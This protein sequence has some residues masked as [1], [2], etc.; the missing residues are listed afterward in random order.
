MND[1]EP[2]DDPTADMD[3]WTADDL[4]RPRR[5]PTVDAE[6]SSPRRPDQDE[7]ERKGDATRELEVTRSILERRPWPG[8]GWARSLVVVN[9]FFTAAYVGWWSVAGHIG[10]PILFGLLAAAEVFTIGHL[11]GLWQ[12]L[13]NDG[14]EIPPK[15]RRRFDVDVFVPTYGESLSTLRRTV[16]AAVEMDGDHRTYV[17][18]DAVRDEVARLAD[19]CGAEYIPREASSGAKAGNLN[20]ALDRTDGQLVVVF[21]ADHV[22]RRDFLTRL[23]GYFEDPTVAIVQTPQFY[24]NAVDN[25]VAR[26]AWHQ[27]MIFYGPILRGKSD[28]DAAFLCGTN[29]I[30]RRDALIEAGG[31]EEDSVVEDFATSLRMQRD[32][33]RSVYFPY[34]LAEGEG[35]TT[36][37]AYVSQQ[38][39]W[40]SGSLGLLRDLA[41][42]R[43]GLSFLQRVQHVLSS[44]YYLVGLA[45]AIYVSL[46][47]LALGWRLGPF[48]RGAAT[49]LLFYVPHMLTSL[50]NLRRQMGGNFGLRHM[51]YTF[52]MFPTYVVSAVATL[53][54]GSASF[55][56]TGAGSGEHPKPPLLAWATVVVFAATLGAMVYGVLRYPLDA[57]TA[58]SLAWASLNLMLLGPITFRTI[59]EWWRSVRGHPIP[60]SEPAAHG[61]PSS[62]D[63]TWVLGEFEEPPAP[64]AI[65]SRL[66]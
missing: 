45:L 43:S 26:G 18:D 30:I 21:D 5:M 23:L 64:D 31:F 22:A 29:A 25:P 3:V 24:G 66:S 34:V 13:W 41:P 14:I 63:S 56:S 54:G 11:V 16:S 28:L 59:V 38:Q 40:A 52:G 8:R 48:G 57:W 19:E 9:V 20:H 44:S 42:F 49:F 1:H 7:P 58:V 35:P 51:Q 39:R 62:S 4:S 15:S 60:G 37:A 33:W 6:G 55:T 47:I 2:A 12:A 53:F 50:F 10:N 65:L 46:P 61:S 27:Q 17:L 36:L 32:R